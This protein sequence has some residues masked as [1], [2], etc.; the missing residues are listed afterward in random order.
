MIAL[1]WHIV[2]LWYILLCNF[3]TCC[4]CCTSQRVHDWC[5]N[6]GP[7]IFHSWEHVRCCARIDRF[8]LS[9]S[10]QNNIASTKLSFGMG[11]WRHLSGT[12]W[13]FPVMHE[14]CGVALF[15]CRTPVNERGSVWSIH[16]VSA[17]L[18]LPRQPLPWYDDQQTPRSARGWSG[19]SWS[20]P[21][22]RSCT[23]GHPPKWTSF[24]SYVTRSVVRVS[25]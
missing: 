10:H 7:Q 8:S 9:V 15:R 2:L 14:W 1:G 5:I 20:D 3:G 16:S 6:Q 19:Q 11:P 17:T 18:P 22:P 12:S 13:W 23:V 4:F 25:G 21:Q 24:S